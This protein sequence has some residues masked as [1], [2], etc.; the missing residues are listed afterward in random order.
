GTAKGG[1]ILGIVEALRI[2]VR[3]LG[4]GEGLEDLTPFSP[5]AFAAAFLPD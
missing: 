1:A 2:P 4:V 3:F 5:A